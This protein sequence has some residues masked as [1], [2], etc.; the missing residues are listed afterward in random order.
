MDEGFTSYISNKAENEILKE[1][2]ENPHAGSYRG[3]RQLFLQDMKNLY[4]PTQT[5]IIQIGHMEPQVIQRKYVFIAIRVCY[6]CRK[7]CKRT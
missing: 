2:K 1:N 5:D 4:P 6:W 3:Y 7:C